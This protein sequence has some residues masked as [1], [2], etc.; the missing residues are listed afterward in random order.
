M[1]FKNSE[2]YATANLAPQSSQVRLLMHCRK[3]SGTSSKAEPTWLLLQ[4]H[5]LY[6]S[7]VNFF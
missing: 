5:G 1:V 4:A 7:T 3:L 6:M 2:T